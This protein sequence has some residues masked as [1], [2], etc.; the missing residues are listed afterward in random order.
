MCNMQRANVSPTEYGHLIWQSVDHF[1][2]VRKVG[3]TYELNSIQ[4]EFL[5]PLC[6]EM[7]KRALKRSIYIMEKLQSTLMGLSDPWQR[8]DEQR[9]TY[10][11]YDRAKLMLTVGIYLKQCIQTRYWRVWMIGEHFVALKENL[12][13]TTSILKLLVSYTGKDEKG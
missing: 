12:R 1:E 2:E 13:K 9:E 5:H 6:T 7:V 11:L 10:R 8:S 4:C 3:N